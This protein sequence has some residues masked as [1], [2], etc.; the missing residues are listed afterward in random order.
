MRGPPAG[1]EVDVVCERERGCMSMASWARWIEGGNS[2]LYITDLGIRRILVLFPTSRFDQRSRPS[3]CRNLH[4]VLIVILSL[5]PV[6]DA[7]LPL[8]C[9]FLCCDVS[10]RHAT[11][12]AFT[13][14]AP[15]LFYLSRLV[16]LPGCLCARQLPRIDTKHK[17]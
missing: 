15:Y 5:S 16:S 11:S 4:T 7:Y 10:P 8:P 2:H 6:F 13:C 17:L 9:C 1:S 14:S 3:I 12:I